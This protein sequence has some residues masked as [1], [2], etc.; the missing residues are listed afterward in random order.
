MKK[1]H[2]EGIINVEDQVGHKLKI[3]SQMP[4]VR[5]SAA[6]TGRTRRDFVL[7]RL[8]RGAVE[9]LCGLL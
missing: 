3:P 4:M 8:L 2:L 6:F 9:R 7:V 1:W 5:M